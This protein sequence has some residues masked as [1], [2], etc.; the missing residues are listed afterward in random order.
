[1]IDHDGL[2]KQLLSNYF[3]EFI[4]LM[5]PDLASFV[6]GCP[7]KFLDKEIYKDVLSGSKGEADL[8]AEFSHEGIPS[9]LVH[10]E[11]QSQRETD[12]SK[13]LFDYFCK[14]YARHNIPVYP[15][16][17]FAFSGKTRQNKYFVDC[18][19]LQVVQFEYK[20][21]NL[22]A[23]DWRN[24][25]ELDSPVIAA[26]MPK[27]KIAGSEQVVVKLECLKMLSRLHL[28]HSEINLVGAFIDI[29]LPLSSQENVELSHMIA[30][31]RGIEREGVM[32]II[33]SWEKKGRQEGLLEGRQQTS[34]K[35]ACILIKQKFGQIP[36]SVHEQLKPLTEAQLLSLGENFSSFSSLEELGAWLKRLE[37]SKQD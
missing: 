13:R 33:T 36:E 20:P 2:F 35:W 28:S 21:V 11:I 5:L 14:L 26:L 25:K 29:Y 8:V 16:A 9:L 32:E 18:A 31:M 1:M 37:K 19:D 6:A 17:V 22:N 30:E 34:V 3:L 10:V 4:D 23:L 15:V 12:F 7:F 24:Y 27:M